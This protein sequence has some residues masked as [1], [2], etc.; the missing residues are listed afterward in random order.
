VINLDKYGNTSAA[1]IPLALIDAIEEKKISPNNYVMLVGFGA[2][3]TCGAS[4]I[5]WS[6]GFF[7]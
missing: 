2:G 3:L 5:K 1:S 4:L 7:K 6:E